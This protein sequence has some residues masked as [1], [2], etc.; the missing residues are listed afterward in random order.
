MKLS[1]DRVLHFVLR[2]S[3]V[4]GH[5]T[6]GRV[7]RVAHQIKVY[8][9]LGELN[10]YI[11]ESRLRSWCVAEGGRQLPEFTHIMPEDRDRL[12]IEN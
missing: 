4:V 8:N 3:G 9:K 7:E 6:S 2:E 5:V 10:E 11:S 1:N 12:A